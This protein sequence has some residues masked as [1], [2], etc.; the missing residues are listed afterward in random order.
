M[1]CHVSKGTINYEVCGE[2]SPVIV[3]HAMG[4]DH[5]SMKAWLEPIF[6]ERKDWQRIYLDIPAHGKSAITEQ[7]KGTEDML[8]MI[9]EFI[10]AVLPDQMF[11]V[12]GASFGGYLAQGIVHKKRELITGISLI[13]SA[14]HLPGTERTLPAKVVFEVD[15]SLFGELDDDI[16]K[17]F[18][19]LMVHQNKSNLLTFL[20]DV[21]PGRLLANRGFLASDWKKEGYYYKFDPLGNFEELQQPTLIVLGK[22]DSICG[23]EDHI[24]LFGKYSHASLAV[25]DQAGHMIQIEQRE[26]LISLVTDW[27]FRIEKQQS[28]SFH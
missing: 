13:A 14:L 16:L 25:L 2:G 5:R 9:I 4:T 6:M 23:Y 12:I 17:A 22:Q 1:E 3:L 24:K 26:V 27:L 21:Q 19:L 11:S 18:Q 7:V 28:F 8:D 10:D 20:K 15:K